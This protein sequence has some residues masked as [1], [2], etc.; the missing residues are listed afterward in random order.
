MGGE[1]LSGM[2]LQKQTGL[3]ERVFSQAILSEQ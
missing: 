3:A 2:D 1:T